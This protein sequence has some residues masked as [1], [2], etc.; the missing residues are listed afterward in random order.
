MFIQETSVKSY[1][2]SRVCS[3]MIC[4]TKAVMP[5]AHTYQIR[6]QHTA[7]LI[8]S[9]GMNCGTFSLSNFLH[10]FHAH[11]SALTSILTPDH[12]RHNQSK[13]GD[14]N[15]VAHPRDALKIFHSCAATWTPPACRSHPQARTATQR[16]PSLRS[17]HSPLP[18]CAPWPHPHPRS[19]IHH[20]E[21]SNIVLAMVSSRA[22]A[23][24][25]S[26]PDAAA[27]ALDHDW[28]TLGV[29]LANLGVHLAS[30]VGRHGL[31]GLLQW[32]AVIVPSPPCP[33][34][35]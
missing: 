10:P 7:T 28:H 32:L 19:E 22:L 13:S 1:R 15:R 29:A 3:S 34:H 17:P 2:A 27:Q 9:R 11:S 35:L 18:H 23:L 16:L 24:V 12:G 25:V 21:F 33:C 8:G 31:T 6:L 20:L 26:Q 5:L 14:T 30:T 4:A